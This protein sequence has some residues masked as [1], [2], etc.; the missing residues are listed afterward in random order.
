MIIGT[1]VGELS[2][3][4]PDRAYGRDSLTFGVHGK[5]RQKKY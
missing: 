3:A 4:I 1:I 5:L 2:V